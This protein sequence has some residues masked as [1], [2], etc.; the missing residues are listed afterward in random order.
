MGCQPAPTTTP[1]SPSP[2]S[3]QGAATSR[4]TS[5]PPSAPAFPSLFSIEVGDAPFLGPA[6]GPDGSLWV[7][8]AAGTRDQDGNLVLVIVW[9]DDG[10]SAPRIT[11]STSADGATWDVGT[12]EIFAGLAIGAPDPG[13]IPAAIVQ[14]D[15]GSWQIYGWSASDSSGS[16]FWSWRTSARSLDGPWKLDAEEIL[17]PGPAGDWDAQMAAAASVLRTGDG[18]A[19]WYE[20][21]PPGSS[22]RGDIGFAASTDGLSWSKADDPATAEPPF[23]SSDPVLPTSICGPSTSVAV[24]QAQVEHAG[25]GYVALFGG[26]AAP[27]SMMAIHGAVGDDGRAW[28][29]GTPE[30]LLTGDM[31]G[32]GDGI[33]TIATVPLEDGRIGLIAESLVTDHSE[34][35]WADVTVAAE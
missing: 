31:L 23:A 21:E 3:T 20:G 17:E 16:A 15:D 8:P 2:A 11:I 26:F 22:N 33:H 18:F 25:D 24:E 28:R 35:W 10:S 27:D 34:L 29:C 19:M 6:D 1:T 14:L 9:F 32:G 13:P 4:G 30:P 7:M 5:S 12:T